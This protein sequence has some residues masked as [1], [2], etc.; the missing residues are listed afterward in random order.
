MGFALV[1]SFI[2]W[3]MEAP[4]SSETLTRYSEKYINNVAGG[5]RVTLGTV[6]FSWE[7]EEKAL[8]I[9]ATGITLYNKADNVAAAFPSITLK[10]PVSRLLRG[11]YMPYS[12]LAEKPEFHLYP[13]IEN[14]GQQPFSLEQ[15]KAKFR[16]FVKELARIARKQEVVIKEVN[17]THG[18]INQ[19]SSQ[20]QKFIWDINDVLLTT[21]VK[22][23]SIDVN[24]EA[25]I[26]F[27]GKTSFLK[28]AM[29]LPEKADITGSLEVN[30]FPASI[31]MYLSPAMLAKG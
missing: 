31:F 3:V 9:E 20:G 24:A 16:S 5:L 22:A 13:S 15:A 27:A 26:D 30:D 6:V 23:G 28:A 7:K 18:K 8:Q 4:R 17:I 1:G 21:E 10:H 12:L 19:Y 11:N 2:L 25:L 14:G 29:H